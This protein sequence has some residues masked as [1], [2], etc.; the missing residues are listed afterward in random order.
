MASFALGAVGSALG[1]PLGG[2]IGATIG[3]LIDNRLFPVKAEGP[4]LN[5]LRVM[6]GNYGD[7]LPVLY[8][9]RVRLAGKLIWSTGLIETVTRTRQGG[10]G[11]PSVQQTEYTY[12]VSAAFAIAGSEVNSLRKIIANGKVIYDADTGITSWGLYSGVTFYPGNFTQNPD[13][14]IES[15]EGAGLVQAYRGTSYV[16]IADL[17][18][19]DYGNRLPNMEFI[20]EPDAVSDLAQI[21]S[22]VCE[23]CGLDP[24]TVSTYDLSGIEVEGFSIGNASSG[25]GALQPLAL[26][27]NFDA[28]E[29]SGTLRFVRRGGGPQGVI[30]ESML[31]GHE[32]GTERP[33]ALRWTTAKVTDLPREATVAYIDLD[34][35][36][37]PGA[38]RQQ[39]Q[40]GTSNNNLS[41]QLA[42]V[43]SAD[44]AMAIADR[45]LWEP[46]TSAQSAKAF[47]DDRL[48]WVA[49][50]RSYLF[51]TP[52]GF[53][54]LRVQEVMRGANGVIE[55]TLL[56]DQSMVYDPTS[57]GAPTTVPPNEPA[58][59]G[60]TIF[61]AIDAPLL[62][63]TDDNT[64]F[65]WSF[66]AVETGW[67]GA[68]LLRS[69][70]GG[71][72]Y[73]PVASSGQRGVIGELEAAP[74]AALGTTWDLVNTILVRIYDP[75]LS[76][77]SRS[78]L[79]VLN[80]ANVCWIG[81]WDGQDGEV[82][83]FADAV[84]ISD[85]LW[86]LST[87]LRG[88][89]GTEHAIGTA[90]IG[91]AFLL[92]EAGVLRRNDFGA[93]DWYKERDYKAVS[94]LTSEADA[95]AQQFTNNG[96]SKRPLSP[97][98]AYADRDGSGDVEIH[99]TRRSR[100]EQPGV[101]SGPVALGEEAELYEL[102]LYNT[103]G[104]AVVR[105]VSVSTPVYLYTAAEQT[106]DGKTPGAAVRV[107]VF[108]MSGIRGRGRPGEFTV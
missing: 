108:Q 36:L 9:N 26:A 101:G 31:C 73:D 91:D 34:R 99:W 41:T 6:Q 38:Q 54:P 58:L 12:R 56:R 77:E 16:V 95:T 24:L 35:D 94:L 23:R 66:S 48:A 10:K 13:P 62:A 28:A 19:A 52:A 21:V 49:P 97:V 7:V 29:E 69:L 100:L 39:R 104:T 86:E 57:V 2:F 76:L 83:Q 14:V 59:P 85:D 64:G 84:Q 4:R 32:F 15:Y 63:D 5:D 78:E 47:S 37:Q 88:R 79:D 103:A 81:G 44:E 42:L 93:S 17:Q 80:G 105:T 45:L 96:E 106:A 1:G 89:V 60:E 40:V 43:L 55:M 68:T 71:A 18:L 11:G 22:D 107:D 51:P 25:I 46:W 61:L 30:Q 67:R 27:Y 102:D 70:D 50:G 92:L 75:R 53:E 33:E 65:Y 87:L 20:V 3:S 72:S 82:L 90:N 8:G 74:G 98:N